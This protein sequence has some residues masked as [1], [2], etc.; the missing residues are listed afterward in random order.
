MDMMWM[1]SFA[2]EEVHLDCKDPY[3]YT[4]NETDCHAR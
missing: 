1:L 2:K 3:G 4:L